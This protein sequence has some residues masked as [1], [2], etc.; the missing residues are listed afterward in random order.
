M[1]AVAGDVL[2]FGREPELA[3]GVRGVLFETEE[4]I[5][6][7]WISADRE[8]SGHVGR[9]LDSLPRDHRVV[10][11]TVISRRLAGMLRRRG[12]HETTEY[13]PEFGELVDV[14]ERKPVACE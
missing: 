6:I 3:T 2:T 11:P 9:Y 5:Y 13:A 10:F 14:Y 4:G 8:G 7:P 12:F 1:S